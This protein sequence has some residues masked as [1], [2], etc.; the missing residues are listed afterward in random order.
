MRLKLHINKTPLTNNGA[1]KTAV[2]PAQKKQKTKKRLFKFSGE[3]REK[4][5]AKN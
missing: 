2:N 4:L 1:P 3:E 5:P